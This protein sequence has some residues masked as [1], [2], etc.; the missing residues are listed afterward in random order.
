M[1]MGTVQKSARGFSL[2]H[3][4][5]LQDVAWKFW[6]EEQKSAILLGLPGKPV[7]AEAWHPKDLETSQ[8]LHSV[9]ILHAC[10]QVHQIYYARADHLIYYHGLLPDAARPAHSEL[11]GFTAHTRDIC[12]HTHFSPETS[13]E[14]VQDPYSNFWIHFG[15]VL[16]WVSADKDFWDKANA[17]TLAY[18]YSV[19]WEILFVLSILRR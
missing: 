9:S 5:L 6:H 13:E 16:L 11:V 2:P 17:A 18:S 7:T 19:L 3:V 8:S 12:E 15:S 1:S 14:E 10:I 4:P